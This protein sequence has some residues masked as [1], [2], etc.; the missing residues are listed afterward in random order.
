MVFGSFPTWSVR[1]A[2]KEAAR[3]RRMID[4]GHDPLE[5][6]RQQRAAPDMNKLL[7]DYLEHVRA[8]LRSWRSIRG[9]VEQFIRPAW[10][11]RKVR[12]VTRADAKALHLEITKAGTPIRANRTIAIASAIFAYAIDGDLLEVNPC[13]GV[14]RNPEH[15]R[16]RY[17]SPDELARLWKVLATWPDQH[18]AAAVRLL[19]LTGCRRGELLGSR[20]PE[21]DLAAAVWNK[22]LERVK[23]KR[24]H[25]LPLSP[26]AVAELLR[27]P[28]SNTSDYLFPNVLNKGHWQ[29]VRAWPDIRE[30]AG[31]PDVR[32]HDQRHT[33]ASLLI[34]QNF[35]LP[36]VGGLLD[37][38]QPST[39]AR[40]THLYDE[41]LRGATA[42]LGARLVPAETA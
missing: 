20:W 36:I 24:R 13:V 8:T 32:L 17:L 19:L 1:E 33:V 31:I 14:R 16:E 21:F 18:A 34:A 30:A 2:R 23:A 11:R 27:L 6:K 5:E 40:Y 37:H 15:R 41:V 38:S 12:D 7:D 42:Q 28:R 10:G 26:E 35:S 39:T 9:I 25:R 4:T 29:Q 3:L 22:P